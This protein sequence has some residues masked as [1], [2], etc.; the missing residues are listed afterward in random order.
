[1]GPEQLSA[2]EAG[3]RDHVEKQKHA[4]QIQS[5]TDSTLSPSPLP[6][7]S[8]LS[9][10]ASEYLGET[11]TAEHMDL[12]LLLCCFIS[13]LSDSGSFNTWSCFVNM[14]TGKSIRAL[15]L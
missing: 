8:S 5:P 11:I 2:L 6:S 15:P 14:Q 1:M 10:R 13:G 3:L 4:K 9:D 7:S 12:I